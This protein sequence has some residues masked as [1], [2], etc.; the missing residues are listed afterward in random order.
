MLRPNEK[1][2]DA[3]EEQHGTAKFGDLV[4][5][6]EP[7]AGGNTNDFGA[8]PSE[9]PAEKLGG[10]GVDKFVDSQRFIVTLGDGCNILCQSQMYARLLTAA[11]DE[12]IEDF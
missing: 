8:N 10:S 2:G 3:R 1:A 5:Q 4:A 7:E 9:F 6:H 12:T 11:A